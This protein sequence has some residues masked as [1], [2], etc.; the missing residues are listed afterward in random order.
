MFFEKFKRF[1]LIFSFFFFGSLYTV[2]NSVVLKSEFAWKSHLTLEFHKPWFQLFLMQIAMTCYEIPNVIR[3]LIVR[4]SKKQPNP[5]PFPTLS[6]FRSSA[7]PSICQLL[8]TVMQ[9]Y[10]LIYIP[11][12]VWQV[13][14]GFQVLF[15]TLFAVTIRKQKLYLVDWLGLFICVSGMCFSGVSALLRGIRS[16]NSDNITRIFFS[17]I[18]LIMAHGISA[19]QTILEEKL[20]HETSIDSVQLISFEG[21]WGTY[22]CIFICLP[23]C[24]ILPFNRT[25]GIYE[26]TIESFIMLSKSYTLDLLLLGYMASISLYQFFGINVTKFS[27]AIHRNL[28]EMMRPFFVWLISIVAQQITSNINE[29]LDRYSFLEI[30]GFVFSIFGSLIYNRVIRF[31]CFTYVEDQDHL[32]TNPLMYH[33]AGPLLTHH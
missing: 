29:P 5:S 18:I 26:N 3:K 6:L 16:D 15:A 28:Y 12:A 23:I 9:F 22:I 32:N 19:Y 25:I 21:I 2:L 24:S 4:T 33:H 31:P 10:G 30:F 1:C 17:F 13:F 20:L 8:S 27:T 14:F 7:L 11:A